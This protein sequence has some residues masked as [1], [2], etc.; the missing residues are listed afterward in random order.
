MNRSCKSTPK[1]TVPHVAAPSPVI[2]N[3]FI[4][5]PTLVN[6][7]PFPEFRHFLL[8]ARSSR[9]IEWCRAGGNLIMH[10]NDLISFEKTMTAE[11][12]QIRSAL[13]DPLPGEQTDAL[14][15]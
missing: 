9:E 6:T 2:L 12:N 3:W 5:H 14:V 8:V 4:R 13:G 11:L 1:R 10:S 7:A 15:V